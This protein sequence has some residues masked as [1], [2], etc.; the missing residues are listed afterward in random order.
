MAENVSQVIVTIVTYTNT[1]Y[2]SNSKTSNYRM[3]I[4]S[5]VA[6]EKDAQKQQDQ[7]SSCL[8]L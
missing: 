1:I 5:L 6:D 4:D 3:T 7:A 8:L 2:Y